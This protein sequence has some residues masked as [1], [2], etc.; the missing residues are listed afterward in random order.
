MTHSWVSGVKQINRWMVISAITQKMFHGY[1]TN[2]FLW[3][4]TY[5]RVNTLLCVC[6][7]TFRQQQ[8]S[9]NVF[10]KNIPYMYSH[11]LPCLDICV[12]STGIRKSRSPIWKKDFFLFAVI[13]HI[14]L[15]CPWIIRI[16]LIIHLLACCANV[17]KV[18]LFF[19]CLQCASH[20]RCDIACHTSTVIANTGISLCR[21]FSLTRWVQWVVF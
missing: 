18:T 6:D 15:K 21:L 7:I 17:N 10:L 20:T 5:K 8:L 13:A 9:L 19:S 3:F 11:N 12:F 14:C 2:G 1:D 16:W 4:E